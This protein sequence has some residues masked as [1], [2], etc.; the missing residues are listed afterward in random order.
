MPI[1]KARIV[2]DRALIRLECRARSSAVLE[3]HAEIEPQQR[4]IAAVLD[5]AT[6]DSLGFFNEAE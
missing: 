5:Y 1:G 3:Q 4:I 6:I 2:T